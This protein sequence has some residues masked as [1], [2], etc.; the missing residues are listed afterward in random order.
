MIDLV[1]ALPPSSRAEA[2]RYAPH[3]APPP[4]VRARVALGI[5]GA[6]VTGV[7]AFDVTTLR[8][9]DS[10]VVRMGRAG[11][12]EELALGGLDDMLGDSEWIAAVERPF[13]RRKDGKGTAPT[14][15]AAF[16]ARVLDL[17]A[18]RRAERAGVKLRRPMILRPY[19]QAWR[20][21]IGVRT[22]GDTKAAALAYARRILG[23]GVEDHNEA[24]ANLIAYF[25]ARIAQQ[26]AVSAIALGARIGRATKIHFVR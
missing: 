12:S 4:P 16:W 6:D 9:L 19:P 2:E 3:A 7:A 5:D 26:G 25:T 8:R 15:A 10:C 21:T 18:R 20:S 22:T 17:L 23:I 14:Y 1:E 24:E 11:F 13:G